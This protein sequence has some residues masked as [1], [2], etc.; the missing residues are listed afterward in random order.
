MPMRIPN[1]LRVTTQPAQALQSALGTLAFGGP[2]PIDI[3][4][5]AAQQA[6]REA[7]A[8][9]YQEQ[10]RKA[11][12]EAE[13]QQ[14]M[15]DL[16]TDAGMRRTAAYRAG[17]P[18]T[19]ANTAEDYFAGRS[20]EAGTMPPAGPL[21]DKY[22]DAQFA[23][24]TGM[25]DKS[26]DPLQIEKS[27]QL[28]G[29]GRRA[30][31]IRSGELDPLTE[32]QAVFAQSGKAPFDNT[33]NGTM[34]LL[35]GAETINP[36]GTARVGAEEALAASRRALAGKYGADTRQTEAETRAGVRMGAPVLVD[37]PEA[38]VIYTA[39]S[40]AIGRPAGAKPTDRAEKL[41]PV[42]GADGRTTYVPASEAAGGV[43]PPKVAG[44]RS[45]ANVADAATYAESLADRMEGYLGQ[46]P[47]STTGPATSLVRGFESMANMVAPGIVD[48]QATL[49]AQT[50]ESLITALGA[51]SKEG[52]GKLSNQD[53][54]RIDRAIGALSSGTPD[55]LKQGLSD[56]RDT[57]DI[58]RGRQ[59]RSA[60][61]PAVGGAV[62]PAT[63]TGGDK[64]QVGQTY[65][66]RNGNRA[67]YI[68]NGQW[69]ESR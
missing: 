5:R 12:A 21:L 18:V 31:Q 53:M 57:I 50:K 58:M 26:V 68:G 11:A 59:P 30:D 39:P 38:G 45:G 35:T 56:V 64:F 49:A 67:V 17:I 7:H 9:L 52:R 47:R 63:A 55:G 3:E 20:S 23:L 24:R 36:V 66:D 14:L 29:A 62:T 44:S 65:V 25:A 54:Q 15:N 19:G 48:S 34:N 6:Q 8:A 27:L 61:R 51:I 60:V 42:L 69:A 2:S 43:V 1:P 46:N 33:A 40:G 22:A 16:R 41:V 32:A 28:R 37:D 4:N 13:A 10:T